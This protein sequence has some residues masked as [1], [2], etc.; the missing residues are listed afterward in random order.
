[1][2]QQ[3]EILSIMKP[4]IYEMPEAQY[5]ADPVAGGSFSASIGNILLDQ[6]P[7]HAWHAHPVLNRAWRPK[8]FEAQVQKR[9]DFGSAVHCLVLE[10]QNTQAKIAVCD[11]GDWRKDVA[12]DARDS[13]RA[14]N[15]T[16]ILAD[17]FTRATRMANAVW[18]QIAESEIGEI[19]L[20][21][22]KAE[23]V[24]IWQDEESGVMCR[25]RMDWLADDYSLILD[26]KITGGSA[27]PTAYA[28]NALPFGELQSSLY[29]RGIE[30]LNPEKGRPAF[31]FACI[32]DEPPY[33]LSLV[34][35]DP[36]WTAL[37]DD[38][39]SEALNIWAECMRTGKWPGYPKRIAYA[40]PP[41]YLQAAWD[42]RIML[43]VDALAVSPIHDRGIQA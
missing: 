29:P 33:A 4:G 27:E 13:A 37:A 12:K 38:K 15:M 14:M 23:R 36:T 28:R 41:G 22:G 9:L 19:M 31:V 30:T 10:P 1:M 3:E 18:N 24:A 7:L 21:G 20:N 16:P 17:D 2:E 32:E 26:L 6:S 34:A 40:S 39:T 42:E 5:H 11:F 43:Q 8:V 35:L 25:S